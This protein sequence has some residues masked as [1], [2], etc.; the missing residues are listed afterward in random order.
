LYYSTV[1]EPITAPPAG[2][3]KYPYSNSNGLSGNCSSLQFYSAQV[4]TANGW[5]SV[6]TPIFAQPTNYYLVIWKTNGSAFLSTEMFNFKSRYGCGGETCI[7]ERGTTNPTP[8][9]ACAGNLYYKACATYVGN[10]GRW[11]IVDKTNKAVS[12]TVS[13]YTRD[14]DFINSVSFT[15]NPKLEFGIATGAVRAEI[16]A[17]YPYGQDFDLKLTPDPTYTGNSTSTTCV[18]SDDNYFKGTARPRP[19]APTFNVAHPTC[20]VAT[21]TV[22]VTAPLGSFEYQ[23]DNGA[24]Q[25]AVTFTNVSAGIRTLSVRSSTE[26]LCI[27]QSSVVVNAQPAT[28]AQPTATLTQPTCT[29]LTG[30]ITVTAPTGTGI[31]YSIDGTTYQ[32]SGTFNDVAVGTYNVTAKNS[33]GCISASRSVTLT[34]YSGTP[35]T[36]TASVTAQPTCT[37]ATG[38]IVVTAPTGTGIEYSIGGTYQSSGTFSGV[39]AGTYSVTAKSGGCI[40]A[41]TQVTVNQQ[42]A[43]PVAPT[44]TV[45]NNCGS[46]TLTASGYTGSLLWSNGATTASITVS[47]AA[48]YTVTQT[49]ANGCTSASGSGA[50]A[51]KAVPGAPTVT[52]ENNCGSSTLTASGYTGSLLWSTGATTASITVSNA[53]TYTVTQTTAN[54]CTSASGSGASAP[55]VVPGAPTVTVENN[56]GSSTLTASGYTGSLLWSTGESTA[57][58]T[59]STA[60][61]YTVTT[62]VNG[63]TSAAGSGTAA[64][65]TTPTA[66]SVTVVDNCNGTSTLSTT[67]TGTLAW[68]TGESTASITVSTAGAY[69]VTTTVNGCTSAAV[70][71]LLHR[72]PLQLHRQ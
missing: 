42:P 51:P 18:A 67:A 15:T 59:V 70:Q 48:T 26:I 13:Y 61:A 28:P 33:D 63:C 14:G 3:T 46:S 36:P 57:S 16:C 55:K 64:P 19:T 30:T 21:G 52:V 17:S 69:T 44:V 12:Y 8:T 27:N 1:S 34:A 24:W 62:T 32:S 9:T 72:R 31:T 39:P 2:Q 50:S 43:T 60:G 66:P 10:S 6:K 25:S 37:V 4:Q 35:A 41:A 68:S 47:N 38:T 65:K 7:L 56:C 45:Q 58:I 53:A 20:T 71:E 40:S 54:G 29:V 23:I 22:T 5:G 11:L 49:T